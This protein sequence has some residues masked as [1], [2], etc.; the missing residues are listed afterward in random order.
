VAK[1]RRGGADAERAREEKSRKAFVCE[2]MNDG[3]EREAKKNDVG[4][5][6]KS[7]LYTIE[8]NRV[9]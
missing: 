4:T 2:A 8:I 1:S 5:F 9:L 7:A 6:A 3:R